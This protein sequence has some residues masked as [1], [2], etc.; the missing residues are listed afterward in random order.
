M[1][2]AL[3]F[4]MIPVQT[5]ITYLHQHLLR[6]VL[7]CTVLGPAC[8]PFRKVYVKYCANGCNNIRDD[9]DDDAASSIRS[10]SS[11]ED[12]ET[13]VDTIWPP[14]ASCSTTTTTTTCQRTAASVG[15]SDASVD[16]NRERNL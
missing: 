2:T 15:R 13:L 14:M 5:A 8:P 7:Y 4:E 3:F 10:K 9:D 11:C 1:S 12:E 16:R 6:T